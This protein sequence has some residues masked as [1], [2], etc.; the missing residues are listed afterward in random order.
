[1]E[2][3]E[4]EMHSRYLPPLL[5][6]LLCWSML[7]SAFAV[8][9][10]QW[11]KNAPVRSFTDE[12]WS[13]AK[14]AIEDALTNADDG[15]AVEWENPESKSH[16]SVTPVATRTSDGQTCRDL[17]IKNYANSREGSGTYEYCQKPDGTWGLARVAPPD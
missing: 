2:K 12:D 8:G 15:Q 9:D 13:L 4:F 5:V 10:L 7:S 3:D 1:M 17:L 16:G 11:L 14:A 6:T